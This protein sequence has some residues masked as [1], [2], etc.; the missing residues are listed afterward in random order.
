MNADN[1]VTSEIITENGTPKLRINGD[2][3][4]GLAYITYLTDKECYEDFVRAGYRIFSFSRSFV[5]IMPP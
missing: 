2:I 4:D 3:Q 5:R 1:K